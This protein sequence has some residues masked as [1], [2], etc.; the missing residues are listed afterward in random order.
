MTRGKLALFQSLAEGEI[1]VTDRFAR[2][3]S[4]CVLCLSCRETCAAQIP[5]EYLIPL[6]RQ[7]TLKKMGIPF[8]K[9]AALKFLSLKSPLKRALYLGMKVLEPLLLSRIPESSGLYFRYSFI[10]DKGQFIPQLVRKPFL[11]KY[12]QPILG[13]NKKPSVLFFPGCMVNFLYPSIGESVVN[14]LKRMGCTVLLP[15]EQNC[16]G[17]PALASG[18]VLTSLKLANTNLNEFAS[19]HFDAIVVACA[20]C[21]T[22]FKRIYDLHFR[23]SDEKYSK[24]TEI[25]KKIFDISEFIL[26]FEGK[27]TKKYLSKLVRRERVTYHDPCHLKKGQNIHTQPREVISNLSGIDLVEMEEPSSCCGFG[28]TFSLEN[29]ELSLKINDLKISRVIR[30]NTEKVLTGCPGCIMQLQGG[31]LRHGSKIKVSH[32]VEEVL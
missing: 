10:F 23:N 7:E 6:A 31:L 4:E 8:K 22:A 25:R 30:S 20:S 28:G 24:W 19:H 1:T 11:E 26:G 32:W 12:K 15:K 5:I 13:T 14:I 21:G 2:A 18:D 16:C 9:K 29:Y 27:E 3:V 17:F